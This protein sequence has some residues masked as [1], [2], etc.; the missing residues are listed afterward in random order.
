MTEYPAISVHPRA[1]TRSRAWLLI[2]LLYVAIRA[3][4]T[5]T[6]PIDRDQGTYCLIGQ[7]LLDGQQLYR[8][9]WDNKP[10][11]IF[12]IFAVIVKVFGPVMW[13][14]G[15]VDILWLLGFSCLLFRFAERYLGTGE[16]VLGVVIH[17]N[18][19]V[20]AG[21]W[22][23]AQPETFLLLF[24]LAS[25]FLMADAAR[26]PKLRPLAAGLLFGAAFWVKYNAVAFLPFLLVL[27]Y[28]DTRRLDDEPRGVSLKIPWRD[29]FRRAA[30]FLGGFA[31]TVAMVL[32]YFWLA[33]SWAAMQEVQFEVLPRYAAMAFERPGNYW[34]A[35]L[36]HTE[37]NLGFWTECATLAAL[38]IAWARREL[39]GF[40]PVLLSAAMGYVSVVM[41]GR[42]HDYTFE[43]CIPFFAMVWGYLAVKVYESF[44]GVAR[45][46][47]RRGWWMARVVVWVLFANIAYWPV[48]DEITNWAVDYKALHVWS[49]DR[50]AFYIGYLSRHYLSHVS[51]VMR[52]TRYLRTNSVS[53]DGLFIWGTYPQIYFLTGSR[54][55]TRFVSNLALVSPW[56][57]PA[58]RDELMRDLEKSRPRFLVVARDDEI[59]A[60]TYTTWDSEKYLEAFADLA[61]F[62]SDYYR[63]A[64]ALRDFL[65]YQRLDDFPGDRG[66]SSESLRKA[67]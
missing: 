67:Q 32:A 43:T 26:W 40:A 28:L 51:G 19:H 59:P 50:E 14:V 15:V 57:P 4:P 20:Q 3:L 6:Y 33:G 37:F 5:L 30:I 24:V 23:A 49:E 48:P 64:F 45:E 63:P 10:P 34:L 41:Q 27:P 25:F 44:R 42:F 9:L 21:N 13:S 36:F 18:W 65:V 22:W 29:W 55:P 47:A 38:L 17:A 56:A 12:Y 39:E 52:V 16:A 62:I 1:A 46:C 35:A 58:W 60:L 11:G 61:I 8:D 66:I 54:P 2:A 7:G 31:A 53:S